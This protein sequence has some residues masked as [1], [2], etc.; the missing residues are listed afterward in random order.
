MGKLKTLP[1]HRRRI[2]PDITHK[3]VSLQLFSRTQPLPTGYTSQHAPLANTAPIS[4]AAMN[5]RKSLLSRLLATAVRGRFL[6]LCTQNKGVCPTSAS[7]HH[8]EHQQPIHSLQACP[9]RGSEKGMGSS[10]CCCYCPGSPGPRTRGGSMSQV[11]G[12]T[13]H[14]ERNVRVVGGPV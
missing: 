3:S 8:L 7:S 2:R 12:P 14:R 9:S 4:T 10:A 1:L 11:R 6:A 5:K 13:F